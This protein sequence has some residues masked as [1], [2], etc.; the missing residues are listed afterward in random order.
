MT[1]G[2]YLALILRKQPAP[3]LSSLS[4]PVTME[5]LLEALGPVLDTSEVFDDAQRA[6]LD[7]LRRRQEE[8]HGYPQKLHTCDGRNDTADLHQELL[9]ALW[10]ATRRWMRTRDERHRWTVQDLFALYMDEVRYD[11][12]TFEV[13][14]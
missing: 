3:G 13:T 10:Y 4:R 1:L 8:D 12:K 7:L 2:T 11:L 9:D 14:T 5:A 6:A